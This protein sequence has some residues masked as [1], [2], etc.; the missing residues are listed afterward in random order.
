MKIL[1]VATNIG[2]GGASKMMVA[3]AN[4]LAKKHDVTFLTFRNSDVYQEVD[5]RVKITHNELYKNKI[6][7]LENIGQILAL[8]KYIKKEKFDLAI[9]FLHPANYMVSIATKGLKTRSLLSERADPSLK[10]KGWYKSLSSILI[11]ILESTKKTADFYV[12][13]TKEAKSYYPKKAQKNSVVIPNPLPD[14]AIPEPYSDEREKIIVNVARLENIQK[15]QDVLIKA[16]AEVNKALP[17]YELHLYGDGPDEEIIKKWAS[18]SSAKDKIK[19]MGVSR[20]VLNDIRDASLF[21]L[22]SD[23]EGIPNA[24]LEA[25]AVG[26]PC[27]STDC[28]PGGA[29]VLIDS[30]ENGIIVPCGDIEKLKDAMIEVLANKELQKKISKNAVNVIEKFNKEKILNMWSAF[31]EK[32]ME[33]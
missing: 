23:Y 8:R 15:R 5:E 25:L 4:H 7:P 14:K 10:T 27:I 19:F 17:E 21:V 12:F 30:Y 13:Q 26:L 18:E 2:Y 1:F 3:V 31:I 11:N 16:F 6:K 28:S 24:L 9:A 29:R 32:T 20:D 33:K 22:S